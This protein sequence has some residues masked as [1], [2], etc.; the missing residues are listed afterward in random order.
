MSR[1]YSLLIVA[2]A[3]VGFDLLAVGCVYAQQASGAS[4]HFGATTV[5]AAGAVTP[6]LTWSTEP[7]A[8][9]CTALGD[10]SGAKAAS[11]TETLPAVSGSAT[12]DITCTWSASPS[13]DSVTLNWTL[14]TMN[15]DGSAYTDEKSQQVLAAKNPGNLTLPEAIKQTLPAT[16]TTA[17]VGPLDAGTWYFAVRAINERNE[18]GEPSNAVTAA[19]GGARAADEVHSTGI[20]VNAVPNPPTGLQQGSPSKRS[21]H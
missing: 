15:T 3:L 21:K 11:G 4:I 16:A 18:H 8:A 14:P 1:V 10:W 12:F 9:S 5:T 6:T 19:V 13:G 2:L 17:T 20:T 7:A